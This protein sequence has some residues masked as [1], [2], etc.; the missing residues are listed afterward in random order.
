MPDAAPSRKRPFARHR[1][2]YAVF[3]I[4]K[5]PGKTPLM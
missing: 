3:G 2:K 4:G 5:S 1:L